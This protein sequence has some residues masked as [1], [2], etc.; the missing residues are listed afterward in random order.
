MSTRPQPSRELGPPPVSGPE[1]RSSRYLALRHDIEHRKR[2]LLNAAGEDQGVWMP[3]AHA[4]WLERARSHAA[5]GDYLLAYDMAMRGLD[6]HPQG[7][8]LKHAAVLALARSGAT[9]KARERYREFGLGDLLRAGVSASLDTDI[10]SLEGPR[11]A[12]DLALAASAENRRKLLAKAATR[13]RKIFDETGDYYPGV[14]TATLA[15]LA[16]YAPE[17][18]A[19]GASVRT[20]RERRI[21]EGGTR[22]LCGPAVRPAAERSASGGTGAAIDAVLSRHQVGVGF[23]SLASRAD[24]VIAEVLLKHGADLELVFPFRL[25]ELCEIS[26]RPAGESWVERFERCLARARSGTFATDDSYLGDEYLFTY[27]TWLGIGLALQRAQSLDTEARRLAIWD[28]CGANG[29][30]G[31]AGTAVDIGL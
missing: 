10:A 27:T 8:A 28:R 23:G 22:L 3:D 15:L 9:S 21:G 5:T 24:I 20:I 1:I 7:P 12:K 11:I 25:D 6:E 14:N 29:Q 16:G 31:A 26:V 17:A 30:L 19:L 2:R 13:Y 4:S 18:K